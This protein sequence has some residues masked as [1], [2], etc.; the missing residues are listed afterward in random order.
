MQLWRKLH[1]EGRSRALAL[2]LSP[3]I[4]SSVSGT[5]LGLEGNR[6]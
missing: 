6:V 3:C 1:S 2:R 5:R 4:G